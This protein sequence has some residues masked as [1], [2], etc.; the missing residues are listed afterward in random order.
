MIIGNVV[1]SLLRLTKG[2]VVNFELTTAFSVNVSIFTS[3]R[4]QVISKN[5]HDLYA[6][7]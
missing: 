6:N 1:F 4:L 5:L 7:N 3:V 2:A